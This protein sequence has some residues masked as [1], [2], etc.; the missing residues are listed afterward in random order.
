MGTRRLPFVTVR[1]DAHERGYQHGQQCGDLIARYPEVLRSALRLEA[2]WR[3][4]TVPTLPSRE[5]L[6]ARAMTFLPQLTAFAPHLVEEVRGIAEGARL[7]FAEALLVNVRGEVM[8]VT[9]PALAPVEGCT[10]FAIGR[11][12]TADG[13]VLAGQNLDQMPTNQE[14]LIVLRVEPDAGPALLMCT[15]AGLVGYMGLNS[16]GLTAFQNQLSTPVWRGSAMP[17]YFMK[18]VLLEQTDLAGCRAV[19][20]RAPLCSSGNYVLADRAGLL[21]V[22]ATPDGF[23]TIEP[24][25][26]ILVHTNHF[27]H[28]SLTPSE[29]LLPRLPDSACRLPRMRALIRERRG[30]LTVPV[31]QA[32]LADHDGAPAAICRHEPTTATIASLVAEPDHGRLHVALGNPCETP[33]VTYSL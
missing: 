32:L 31:M 17:H 21:D 5:E 12:A 27:C 13:G 24:E 7:S 30:H 23:A 25:D 9:L 15:F 10:A 33:F 19:F 4:L 11:G 16:A 29:A 28:P 6:L 18:R 22:E 14:L 8:G 2:S 26:D 1:G 20:A 3:G